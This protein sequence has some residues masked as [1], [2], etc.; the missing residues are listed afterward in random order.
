MLIT[1][2]ANSQDNLQLLYDET[3]TVYT[4]YLFKGTKIVNGQETAGR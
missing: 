4:S 1:F 3:Q 2:F